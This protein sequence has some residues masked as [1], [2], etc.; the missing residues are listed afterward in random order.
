MDRRTLLQGLLALPV[1]SAL[2]CCSYGA[3]APKTR[4][5]KLRVVL[6][7]AFAVVLQTDR[8]WGVRAFTPRDREPLHNLTVVA[9]NVERS[10][11]QGKQAR[12][13][14]LLS[15]GLKNNTGRQPEI[16]PA[17]CDFTART[18]KWCQE[19]YWLTIDLP[20]PQKIG[21]MGP[22]A[23][24]AFG[25][26]EREGCMPPNHVLEY[27]VIDPSLVRMEEQGKEALRP[28]A[29][30]KLKER[31]EQG[32]RNL[33]KQPS[34]R[35]K[36]REDEGSA[37]GMCKGK[38]AYDSFC[39]HGDLTLFFGVGLGDISANPD[40]PKQFFN[41]RILESF[42]GLNLRIR[43]LGHPGDPC[44]HACTSN[45][46][47]GQTMLRDTTP[48]GRFIEAAFVY[49]CGVTGPTVIFPAA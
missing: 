42:P 32:C 13:F 46:N 7:G 29:C 45:S 34:N 24:V 11:Q 38:D 18:S 41:E 1:V 20:A 5:A 14:T 31:Y 17:L 15:S 48:A 37:R 6:G 19:N 3:R 44:K 36:E 40:H 16:D 8:G 35:T 10:D 12:N 30:D 25:D 2:D 4:S 47:L 21:F 23:P 33:E 43:S 49:D 22:L 9:H 26:P 39:R 28:A 27:D